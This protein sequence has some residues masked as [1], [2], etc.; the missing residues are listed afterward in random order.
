MGVDL[1]TFLVRE[2]GDIIYYRVICHSLRIFYDFT[3]LYSLKYDEYPP[4]STRK[5]WG[6]PLWTPVTKVMGMNTDPT[7]TPRLRRLCKSLHSPLYG[8]S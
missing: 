2:M 8:N 1:C 5:V 6:D 3:F 4:K 7:H